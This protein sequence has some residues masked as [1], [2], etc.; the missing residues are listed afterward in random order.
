VEP[1]TTPE[2]GLPSADKLGDLMPGSGHLVHMP[3]HIYIRTGYYKKAIEANI[4]AILADEDYIAHCQ[5][6]G[7]YPAGYYPHNI[8]F[9]YASSF[10]AGNSAL[11]IDA[12]RKVASKVSPAFID[13]SHFSQEF[14]TARYHAFI[15]FEKWNEMLTEPHPGEEFLHAAA[16]W[17]YGRGMA[18][19]AKGQYSR[20]EAETAKLEALQN[21]ETF[22]EKYGEDAETTKVA[23]IAMC[24][25]K[26]QQALETGNNAEAI[27]Y[28]EKA[29]DVEDALVYNEP[30][31]WLLPVRWVLGPL[32]LQQG[33][34]VKAEKMY[35]EDLD[36]NKDNGWAIYGLMQSL[37]A[38]ERQ[39][40]MAGMQRWLEEAWQ[41]ADVECRLIEF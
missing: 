32:Y 19:F 3:S 29:K 33:E 23:R 11:A 25:L 8:H 2:R 24:M 15:L 9:L 40:D 4:K 39:Y 35:R 22:K 18:F 27:V 37:E 12:A 13:D 34:A 7:I 5:A 36:K 16:V 17:H 41:W 30:A 31:T 10:F 21:S 28:F 38:Q 26:G 20:A 1:S 14:L 6:S